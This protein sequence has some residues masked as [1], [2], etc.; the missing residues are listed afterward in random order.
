LAWLLRQFN[1]QNGF[2][3]IEDVITWY[4]REK[5]QQT[6]ILFIMILDNSG[7][8][9]RCYEKV[10]YKRNEIKHTFAPRIIM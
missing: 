5:K 9:L 1:P 6:H 10:D 8:H 2:V 3:D 7:H 4:K